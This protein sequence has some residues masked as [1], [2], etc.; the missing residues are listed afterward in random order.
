MNVPTPSLPAKIARA[1]RAVASLL[2][3]ALAPLALAQGVVSAGLTGAV[4]DE[5]GKPV[6]GTTLTAVHLPTRTTYSAVSTDT[7]RYHFR[8]MI[9]GGPYS[10]V[11]NAPGKKPVEI[12]DLTTQLGEDTDVNITLGST[13]VVVMEKYTVGAGVD[14]LDSTASG[15]GSVLTRDKFLTQ[16]TAQRS[17]ADMARTNSMVTLRNVFGDRQEGMLTAVGQNSR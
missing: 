4:R 17:F 16:P 9:V 10:L 8:G 11:A 5:G 2:G 6:V 15:A 7:G 3:F 12:T 13:E 14:D 1:T